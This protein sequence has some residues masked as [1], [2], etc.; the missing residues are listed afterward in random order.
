MMTE[1]GPNP[2]ESVKPGMVSVGVVDLGLRPR[3]RSL[4]A[5]IRALLVDCPSKQALF[6]KVL[7]I[8][9]EQV[10]ATV[11]RIDF[12]VGAMSESRMTHDPRM[13]RGLAERFNAEYLS[14]LA[15]EVHDGN[16]PEPKLKRFERG[17]QKMTLISAPVMDI[18]AG[19]VAGTVTLM[20]GGGAYKP[21]I[22]LPRLDSIVAVASAVLMAKSRTLPP[23]PPP[24][25][26]QTASV[27]ASPVADVGATTHTASPSVATPA[28]GSA[29]PEAAALAK[30]SQFES[31]KEFGYSIVNSLCS[32]LQ[33]EQVFFGVEKN[34]RIQVEA[35]SGTP[36]FKASGPGITAARQAMEECLDHGT[37]VIA[38]HDNPDN[39][40]ALPIHKQWSAE[41][42]NSCI[43]SIPLKHGDLVTG[44]IS[45]RR[46]AGKPFRREE[47]AG[48]LQMLSP[49]GAAIR[50]VEKANRSVK[51]QLT[52]AM[53]DS[54]RKNMG[55]GTNGRKLVLGGF[56][57]ALLWFLFGSMTYQPICRTRVTAADLRHIS[58]PFD[59]KLNQVYVRPG[60][61]VRQ[62]ELL[63]EF[64]SAD[65]RLELNS[66]LRQIAST[67]VEFRQAISEDKMSEA[68]LAKSHMNVLQAEAAAV[69]KQIRDAQIVAPTDGTVLLSDLEQRVGQVFRQG[70]E[71]LQFAAEGDW[72]LEIEVPDDIANYVAPEQTGTFAAASFPTEKQDFAIRH[73]DGAA[74]TVQ[75]RNVFIARAPLQSRPEW[76]KTGMEGTAQVTTVPRPVWWVAMHRIVDWGRMNF[77]L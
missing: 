6:E 51:T 67:Q 53:G 69:Q 42:N 71:I 7:K 64:D 39:H 12:R 57:L 25:A 43:C 75:D 24:Q 45:I 66:L 17:D 15:Q 63:A 48:L 36:D 62:G 3:S 14:P 4:N 77:W 59:G 27:G 54:A 9:T 32:Q 58:S 70:D 44:I 61:V 11:G 52:T 35:V 5:Q 21:E 29:G 30:A 76:M 8:C 60:Q 16:D 33:A 50:V 2:E 28:T 65:L 46:P 40:E 73:I 72:L 56:A 13:A 55:K 49:Y 31:T 22:V 18:V 10:P 23:V 38:Q 37:F 1:Q 68:A 34:Q 47:A 20:L 19:E 74:T 26:A 41:T